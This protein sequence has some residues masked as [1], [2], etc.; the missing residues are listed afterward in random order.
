MSDYHQY[1]YKCPY[2]SSTMANRVVCDFGSRITFPTPRACSGYI[3]EYCAGD[4]QHC[5]IAQ[6]I[7]KHYQR[8]LEI[9][10][11]IKSW[12]TTRKKR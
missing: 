8:K 2:I 10:E 3:R 9:M 12:K 4:W 6:T 11:E 7:E 5:T 1:T